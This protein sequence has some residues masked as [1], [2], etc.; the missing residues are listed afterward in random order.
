MIKIKKDYLL[1]TPKDIR[2]S[3]K[4]FEVLGVLNPAAVRMPDGK[5]VLYVR[6]IEK[7]I[8][9]DDEKYVYSPRMVGKEKFRGDL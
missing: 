3:S 6:V 2:P 9:Y 5:I 4:D 8:K 1:L 7:L